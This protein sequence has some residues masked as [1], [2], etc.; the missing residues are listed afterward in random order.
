MQKKNSLNRSF[1]FENAFVHFSYQALAGI[2]YGFSVYML[3]ER[4]FNSSITGIAMAIANLLGLT[5]QPII[6]DYLDKNK[7]VTVFEVVL[8]MAVLISLIYICNNFVSNGSIFIIII[9]ICST[10]LFA[11]LE[12]LINSISNVLQ[13]NNI[14]VNFS[15]ARACGSFSY[16]IVCMAFGVLT[17][18]Y[19][20]PAVIFGGFVFALLLTFASFLIRKSFTKIKKV[21]ITSENTINISF[22]EFIITNKKFV[23]LCVCLVGIFFSYTCQD[24]FMYLV[25]ENVGGDS[26]D[27]GIVLGLKAILEGVVMFGF[28]QIL[29]RYKLRNILITSMIFFTI[30]SLSLSVVKTVSLVYACQAFQMFSFALIIPS[31]I[32]YININIDTRASYRANALFTMTIAGGAIL[33]SLF[34]GI[35]A[36]NLGVDAMNYMS[37]IVS[38][39]SS[40]C[41]ILILLKE[42]KGK[43]YEH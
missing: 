17:E 9:Y 31:M 10:V 43:S 41:F 42:E 37:F 2:I 5:F 34:G 13:I 11:T 33:S 12:P 27:M 30:K 19:S 6:S 3:I 7:K 29:N 32:E 4:G 36:D 14:D 16:G 8:V 20:Y 15:R 23:L 26:K 24:N 21:N 1:S 38:F 28:Y 18:N 39:I 35:V 25:V 22:K 40:V